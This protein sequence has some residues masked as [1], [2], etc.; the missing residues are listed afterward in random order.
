M[1][2]NDRNEVL[3][4]LART[5]YD[6]TG[7]PPQKDIIVEIKD[8]RFS[9]IAPFRRGAHGGDLPD[10]AIVTP[11]LIDIQING[12][13]DVQF[14]DEP[15]PEALRQ[16]A[17]GAERGGSAWILPT[18]V[19]APGRNFQTAID[20][21]R[22]AITARVPGILGLHLE[23]PFLSPHRPGIHEREAIR[24]IDEADIAALSAPFPGPLLLTLA[25]EE[26]PEG[27][28]RKLTENGVIVF[29]GHS[30]ATFAVMQ[31]A[32]RDGL[33]GAT[34]LFNAMSQVLG[35]EPG[36]AGS[37]L[38]SDHLFAGII[39]DGHHVHWN[40]VKLAI[41]LMPDRLCLV[42]D[43]MCT[44]AG[45]RRE[46]VLH[47]ETIRLADGRLT[48][49]DGTLAGAHV[50]MDQC[51]R[52]VVERGLAP[53]ELAVR[54]ASHNPAAALGLAD[55]LGSIQLGQIGCCSTFDAAWTPTGVIRD[56]GDCL[57]SR[58]AGAMCRTS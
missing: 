33:T 2:S 56:A 28:I 29:A 1:S 39:A 10:H 48:N 18:F 24:K 37:V 15:T 40:N 23:G 42:T 36:V 49:S 27:A 45:T 54:M 19:T 41:R 14:N 30:A 51:I 50:A 58:C 32:L 53:P 34:H 11:G 52:N 9:R 17:V 35:R 22:A 20:A 44:L 46:F 12:A 26:A 43:A 47:G 13:N 31:A 3:R 57:P 21:A 55:Q 16:I 25:P 8:G 38:G 7:G 5:L 6:G 4:L